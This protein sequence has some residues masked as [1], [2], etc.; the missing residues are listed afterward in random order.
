M[1]EVLTGLY[2]GTSSAVPIK[3]QQMIPAPHGATVP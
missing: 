3:I 2:Q 1:H